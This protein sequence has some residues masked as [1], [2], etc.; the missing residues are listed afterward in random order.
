MTKM[1]VRDSRG[2][3]LLDP[4]DL[5][6]LAAHLRGLGWSFGGPPT[7]AERIGQGNMNLTVRVR[8]NRQSFILKQARPWVERYPHIAAPVERAAVEA[9]FYRIASTQPA[10][11]TQMPQLFG[12]DREASL[13]WLEDMGEGC[14]FVSLYGG[15]ELDDT[16]CRKL[17]D[18]LSCL[19]ETKVS[20]EHTHILRNRA[21]R[22]LNY[23]HQYVLPIRKNNG[24]PLDRITPGLARLARELISDEDYCARVT[25]LGSKYLADGGTLVH[26]DFFPGSW[27]RTQTGLAIIDGEFCFLG[28][29][30]YDLGVFLAHLAFFGT[31][32]LWSVVESHYCGVT[33]WHLVRQFAGAEIMRRLIGVAQLPIPADPEKKRAWLGLSRSLVCSE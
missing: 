6:R 19:H 17:T 25:D 3:F 8:T 1:D 9:T 15:G 33:D 10:L 32:S 24:L 16:T 14:D 30:E 20:A 18:F 5:N 31:T 4:A 12:F 7:S 23:E 21:M 26:G 2:R 22:A 27:L 13:L 11:A 28:K 29:P